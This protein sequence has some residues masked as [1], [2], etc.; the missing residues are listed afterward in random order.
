MNHKLGIIVPYRNRYSQLEKFLEKTKYYLENRDYNYT[1]IIVEQD[2]ASS[3]NRG[4]LCNIGFKEAIKQ[5]CDYVIFH[6]VD[7]LP[8]VVD[9]SYA[10][11]P[12]HLATQNLPFDS[13]FGGVTLFPVKVFKEINGFSNYYWGWGFEDDDLL[14]RCKKNN[15]KIRTIEQTTKDKYSSNLRLNGDN[16]RITLNNRYKSNIRRV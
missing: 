12:L 15:I 3:F 16:S 13:Y 10:D 6:D 11:I 14:Y 5:K 8:K 7:M 9:Y 4:M 2:D 1:I